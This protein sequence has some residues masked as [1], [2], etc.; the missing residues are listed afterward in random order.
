MNKELI[1]KTVK[2]LIIIAAVVGIGFG[3]YYG[4]KNILASKAANN[5]QKQSTAAVERGDIAVD[6]SGTGTVQP[7]ERYDIIPLVKGNILSAPFEEGMSVKEGD[8]LYQI[9]DSDLSINIEKTK[10][11]ITK[12]HLNNQSDTEDIQNLTVY[13]PFD[14]KIQDITV[15]VGDDISSGSVVSNIISDSKMKAKF[16][17]NASQIKNIEVGQSVQITV[18]SYMTYVEGTVISKSSGTV[19]N[20]QGAVLYQVVVE[21][22][23][24]GALTLDAEVTGMVRTPAGNMYSIGTAILEYDDEDALKTKVA[25]TIKQI[26]VKENDLVK[27]GQKILEMGNDDLFINEDTKAL[28][29]KDLEY[30]LESQMKELEDYNIV[31][32]IDG[33][34]IN[35]DGKA[36]DTVNNTSNSTVLMTVADMSKMTFEM[37]VDELDIAKVKVGQKA[38]ITADA[39]ADKIFEGEVTKI[40]AEGTSQNGVTTYTVEI[41][42]NN[43]DELKSGM[44]VNADISVQKKENVLYLPMAAVQKDKNGTY[45]FAVGEDGQNNQQGTQNKNKQQ[46]GDQQ[47]KPNGD[48]QSGQAQ[49]TAGAV[50]NRV[51]KI[52]KVGINNADYIEI[53]EGLQEGDLVVLP[54]TSS[55]SNN[56]IRA[57]GG[58]GGMGAVRVP[59]MR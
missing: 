32:P 49:Q 55:Q 39:L 34:V 30:T 23:N 24:K 42:I 41:T 3:G 13:A 20:E 59:G 46:A 58:M 5:T 8:L 38:D 52:V 37:Q 10:N 40:A 29:L 43:P 19:A 7:I 21:L 45:V 57:T 15:K 25:G 50:P 31:S 48:G 18:P 14:G 6:I 11:S 51:R 1:K 54:T 56:T 9:D 53:T 27:K 35:K 33:I 47:A 36:G 26:F 17:F 12:F 22:E 4:Y 44:N 2:T 16:S 28:E